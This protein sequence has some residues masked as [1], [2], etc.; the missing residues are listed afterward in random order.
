V[1]NGDVV[2]HIDS[3]SQAFVRWV[4]QRGTWDQLGVHADGDATALEIVRQLRVI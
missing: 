4:T 2:A 1:G 3:D